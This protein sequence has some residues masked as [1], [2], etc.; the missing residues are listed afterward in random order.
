MNSILELRKNAD[1]LRKN[2]QFKEASE[3][4]S[5]L[6]NSDDGK[7]DIWIGW[8]YA[9]CLRHLQEY[10]NALQICREVYKMKPDFRYNNDVYAWCIYYKE[11]KKN[12]IS[13]ESTF[14]KAAEGILKLS[15]QEKYSPYEVTVFKVLDYYNKKPIFPANAILKWSAKL[16]PLILDD[17]T[18][19]GKTKDGKKKELASRKEKYYM[20]R[21]KALFENR[22]YTECI[23]LSNFA[24]RNFKKLH[25][26]NDI[27]FQ[28]YIANSNFMMGKLDIAVNQLKDILQTKKEWFIQKEIADVYL[29]K[30]D[31]K[32]SL[33]YAVASAI[34][35]GKIENKIHLFELMYEILLANNNPVLAKKHIEMVCLIRQKNQWNFNDDFS[36][37]LS[38]LKIDTENLPQYNTLKSELKRNWEKLKYSDKIINSGIIKTILPHGKAGFVLS[39]N[40][41]SYYFTISN[42]NFHPK[43][44]S[45]GLKVTF[46]IED[47]FDKKRQQK[48]K[49]AVNVNLIGGK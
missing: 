12:D 24:L 19:E 1:D 37:L 18:F 15:K 30:K 39:E 7:R 36:K 35:F 20:L 14:L 2:K 10:D 34:N 33:K 22:N 47:S 13:E 43:D 45:E 23:K 40:N 5:K 11:I 8:G 6:W 31:Y 38:K 42:I 29:K 46:Y 4:Y 16:D 17:S 21:I 28:R 26:D 27:W 25:Y 32:K 49:I 44:L 41:E 3:L 48:S 9:F